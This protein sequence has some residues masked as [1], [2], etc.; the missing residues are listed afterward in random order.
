LLQA[1][2]NKIE[3]SVNMQLQKRAIDFFTG[4]ITP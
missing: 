2:Q 1:Q 3:A 4:T